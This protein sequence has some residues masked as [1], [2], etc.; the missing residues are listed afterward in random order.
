MIANWPDCASAGQASLSS[1]GFNGDL[2]ECGFKKRY[3][4]MCQ[5]ECTSENTLLTI[6]KYRFM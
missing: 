3:Q 6:P 5:R 2:A 1:N 4:S